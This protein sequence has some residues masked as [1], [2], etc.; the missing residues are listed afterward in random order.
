[1]MRLD[2]GK[3]DTEMTTKTACPPIRCTP[4][5][6]TY[7]GQRYQIERNGTVRTFQ[8]PIIGVQTFEL[9]APESESVAK[10]I[11]REAARQRR[12]RNR[13][14][15]DAAKRDLGLVCANGGAFGGYE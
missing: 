1:M 15:M 3:G 12:N 6:V 7:Q 4:C 8:P 9:G 5:R 10:L 2:R 14:E 11:R 13:R